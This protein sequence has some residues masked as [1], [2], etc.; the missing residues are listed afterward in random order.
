MFHISKILVKALFK[1]TTHSHFYLICLLKCP[2]PLLV[3]LIVIYIFITLRILNVIILNLLT[4][5]YFHCLQVCVI[6]IIEFTGLLL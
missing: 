4:N 6:P 3:V 2:S 1:E 5:C